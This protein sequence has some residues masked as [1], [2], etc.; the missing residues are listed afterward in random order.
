MVEKTDNLNYSI[1]MFDSLSEKLEKTLNTLRG[2]GKLNEQDIDSALGEIRMAL[3]EAD[4]NLG[5]VKDFCAGVKKKALGKDVVKSLSPG[6]MVIKYVHDE[7][8][9]AMGEHEKVNFR[10]APPIVIMLVGLQGTGKTTSCGKLAKHMRDDLKRRPLLVPADVYRPAAIEQLK[11]L[12]DSLDVEVY[13]SSV[14]QSPVDI[15]QKSYDYAKAS[16]FDTVIL[17]TAGRLQI[18]EKLMNELAEIVEAIE[19]HEIL[20]TCDAMTGQEAVNVAKGFDE[21]LEVDGIILTKL[22]GDARGGAALSMRAVTGKPIKFVGVGEK[23][24]ALEPFYPD[25]LASR[26]LGMGDMLSFIEKATKEVDLKE[27]EKLQKKLKKNQFTLE[28]F[29]AQ[30]QT[31]KKMGSLGSLVQMIPGGNKLA[32]KVDSENMEQDLKRVEAIILSMTIDE[33]QNSDI[34]NGSRRKR[35]AAGSGTSVEEVNML[36]NQF[37]QMRKVMKKFNK[38]GGK[39]MKGL[40]NIGSMLGGMKSP[41][42]S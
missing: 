39:G 10:F 8:V 4:V 15:A 5:V 19:P 29:Y 17:D 14:E 27:A 23:L 12:G 32:G 28:D 1:F 30:L 35:I 7:L 34:L 9:G 41:P 42:F 40:G 21:L 13:E 26:I 11:T 25:R 24:E 18:D 6:Q 36:M 22:D 38:M 2:R 3:L 31:I 16:G 37:K 20:L 33:R